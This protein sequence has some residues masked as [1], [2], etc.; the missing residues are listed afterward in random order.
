MATPFQE[1]RGYFLF[2]GALRPVGSERI[3]NRFQPEASGGLK[4]SDAEK[5]FGFQISEPEERSVWIALTRC[6]A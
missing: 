1:S 5:E 6:P 4:A 2:W 3:A